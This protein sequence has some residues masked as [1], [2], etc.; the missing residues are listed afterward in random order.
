MADRDVRERVKDWRGKVELE[1]M[2]GIDEEI[3]QAAEDKG[4]WVT[5]SDRNLYLTILEKQ[6]EERR[7]KEEKEAT[8]EGR[9]RPAQNDELRR[10]AG[11]GQ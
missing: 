2:R 11:W 5:K 9:E 7:A 6:I 3:R 8:R 1:W 4:V 10:S